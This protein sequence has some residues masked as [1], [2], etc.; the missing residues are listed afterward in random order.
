VDLFWLKS[1]GVAV[2]SG[3]VVAIAVVRF[4]SLADFPGERAF[5]GETVFFDEVGGGVFVLDNIALDV[6]AGFGN[7]STLIGKFV[8]TSMSLLFLVD[9]G[10]MT[11]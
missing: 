9:L 6:R 3:F 4:G 10:G 1:L 2:V 11:S 7:G 8:I 5:F